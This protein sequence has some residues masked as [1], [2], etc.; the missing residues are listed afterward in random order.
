[1]PKE[2]QYKDSVTTDQ[3]KAMFGSGMKQVNIRDAAGRIET[4]YEAPL[5]ASIADKNQSRAC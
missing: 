2:L 1:M 4:L 5:S 3:L